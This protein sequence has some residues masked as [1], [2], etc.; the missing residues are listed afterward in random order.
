LDL[1]LA[2]NY[3]SHRNRLDTPGG[4]TAADRFP[5]DRRNLIADQPVENAASLLGIDEISVYLF[6][7][8]ECVLYRVLC[9]LV[10]HCAIDLFR[11]FLGD[12]LIRKMLAY[13]LA[14]TIGVSGE[15]YRFACLCSLF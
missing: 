15:I 13:S 9:D 2:F 11:R 4:K 8:L 7:F 10:E 5:K 3:Q 1:S 12:D 14:L 6:W